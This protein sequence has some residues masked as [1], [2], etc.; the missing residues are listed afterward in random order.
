MTRLTDI[1]DDK[2]RVRVLLVIG[3]IGNLRSERALCSC[4]LIFES[5]LTVLCVGT[6]LP[7]LLLPTVV[8]WLIYVAIPTGL[9]WLTLLPLGCLLPMDMAQTKDATLNDLLLKAN[10]SSYLKP[11]TREAL[12]KLLFSV[13]P[14]FQPRATLSTGNGKTIEF[15]EEDWRRAQVVHRCAY[16]HWMSGKTLS[17]GFA[18]PLF[19]ELCGLFPCIV[20]LVTQGARAQFITFIALC[21]STIM[22]VC[23]ILSFLWLRRPHMQQQRSA[24]LHAAEHHFDQ[25]QEA[26]GRL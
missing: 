26:D 22:T 8:P 10:Y 9:V 12:D 1:T 3:S 21:A 6:L 18:I 17:I 11:I 5:I 19:V 4:V 16:P 24:V 25:A 2:R 14:T 7:A 15:S 13:S 20:M 23:G